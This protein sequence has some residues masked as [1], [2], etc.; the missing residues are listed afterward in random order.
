MYDPVIWR[1]LSLSKFLDLLSKQRLY[2][3]RIDFFDDQFE[4]SWPSNSIVS[5]AERARID[6]E[7]N[8]RG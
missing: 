2:F 8:Q 1:Y 4:G 7:K 3:N 6:E 5:Q